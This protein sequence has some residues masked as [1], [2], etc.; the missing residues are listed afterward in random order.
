MSKTKITPARAGSLKAKTA[1]IAAPMPK[2][3][4]ADGSV[5]ERDKTGGAAKKPNVSNAGKPWDEQT[6]AQLVKLLQAGEHDSY[7][8]DKLGRTLAGLAA[9]IMHLNIEGVIPSGPY[10]MKIGKG[11][12]A[13][14]PTLEEVQKTYCQLRDASGQ[15]ASEFSFGAVFKEGVRVA[16]ISYNGRAW[17]GDSDDKLLADAPARASESPKGDKGG[18]GTHAETLAQVVA[19]VDPASVVATQTAIV[20]RGAAAGL[21]A[22]AKAKDAGAVE[23]E[24]LAPVQSIELPL[25]FLIAALSVAAKDDTRHFLNG[26]FVHQLADNALRIVGTDGHR[27]F[28]VQLAQKDPIAWAQAGAILPR[29]ELDRIVKY[30]GKG[31]NDVR[32]E[33]GLKHP[34]MKFIEVDGIAVFTVKPI[35]GTFPNYSVI[36]DKAAAA[37]TD[38]REELSQIA[39]DSSYLKAAGALSAQLGSKGVIPYLAPEGAGYPS[40]FAFADVPEAL[41]YVMNQSVGKR[42]ALPASTARLFGADA[43]RSTIANL[44]E[45]IKVSERNI[46]TA[47]HDKFKQASR[48]KI[49][50]LKLRIEQLTATLAPALPAPAKVESPAATAHPAAPSAAGAVVH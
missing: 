50:R 32:I 39:I 49:A 28:V 21:I 23:Q 1:A 6:D 24:E 40:V 48:D 16:T 17:R 41:L 14:L 4:N 15:G 8:A 27:I 25:R 3:R 13:G 11:V 29:E 46:K 34:S 30:L 45:A 43:I 2:T 19:D 12:Y 31:T 33:F 42:E 26:V 38:Q 37:F 18:N 47:K 10:T 35:E 20:P 22:A 9:R 5:K 7:I 36:T 44:Q